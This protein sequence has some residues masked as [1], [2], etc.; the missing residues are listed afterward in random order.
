M[1]C[2]RAV[3]FWILQLHPQGSWTLWTPPVW[4]LTLHLRAEE[5]VVG[6]RAGSWARL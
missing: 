6:M 5:L 1:L 2:S 4:P 3:D